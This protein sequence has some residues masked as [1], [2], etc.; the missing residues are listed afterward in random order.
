MPLNV[1]DWRRRDHVS[2]APR[3]HNEMTHMRRTSDWARPGTSYA[4][5]DTLR[6]GALGLE[7][8][9]RPVSE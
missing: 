7:C 4:K 6:L 2:S 8:R 5:V 9:W 1:A 3:A